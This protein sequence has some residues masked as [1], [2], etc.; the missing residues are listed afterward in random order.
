MTADSETLA[1]LEAELLR[2]VGAA[3]PEKTACPTEVARTVG[4]GHPD[5]WGPLMQPVRK[6]VVRLANEGRLIVTRKGKP[7]D[8]NDFRGVYRI[9]LPRGD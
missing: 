9:G 3:G 5:Q 6:I 7:V 8:P 2:A 1:R 4:G